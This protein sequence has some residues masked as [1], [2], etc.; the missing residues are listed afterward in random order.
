MVLLCCFLCSKCRI[1]KNVKGKP[2]MKINME[3][4]FFLVFPEEGHQ[5]QSSLG[6]GGLS[7]WLLVRLKGDVHM[8]ITC[9][10]SFFFCWVSETFVY[11]SRKNNFFSE[12]I[13]GWLQLFSFLLPQ[14]LCNKFLRAL[15]IYM[16]K[17]QTHEKYCT[18][19]FNQQS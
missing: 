19:Y 16:P 8:D 14:R 1:Q 12:L 10:P 3:S 6:T 7:F 18:G 15:P 4:L 5:A 9:F 11:R 17:A 2:V 13:S